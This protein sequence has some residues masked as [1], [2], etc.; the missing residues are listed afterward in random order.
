MR[1][2]YLPGLTK[3]GR[4]SEASGALRRPWDPRS[5]PPQAKVASQPS[6]VRG[7]GARA[8]LSRLGSL[9]ETQD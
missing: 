8:M 2:A 9:Q 3:E 1:P 7:P 4:G 6:S 5:E